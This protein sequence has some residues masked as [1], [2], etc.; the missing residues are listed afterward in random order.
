MCAKGSAV[1]FILHWHILNPTVCVIS[2]DYWFGV[3][4]WKSTVDCGK[5]FIIAVLYYPAGVLVSLTESSVAVSEE[6]G[7]VHI[8]LILTGEHSVPVTITVATLNGT[9]IGITHVY[10]CF[11]M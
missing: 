4:Y 8:T 11:I 3:H 2:E 5:I 9:A 10:L 6:D 7:L 1:D